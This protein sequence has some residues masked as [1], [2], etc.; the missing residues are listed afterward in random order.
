MAKIAGTPA[1]ARRYSSSIRPAVTRTCWKP[2]IRTLVA[3]AIPEASSAK[4]GVSR[5][6]WWSPSGL[7]PAAA[8]GGSASLSGAGRRPRQR[9]ARPTRPG[10]GGMAGAAMLAC[11]LGAAESGYGAADAPPRCMTV[12]RAG[13]PTWTAWSRVDSCPD[14]SLCGRSMVVFNFLPAKTLHPSACTG[15]Y[16]SFGRQAGAGCRAGV[17]ACVASPLGHT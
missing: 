3:H 17:R 5:L 6:C 13:P 15:D 9:G 12:F 10:L 2:Q 1:R 8:M 7:P 11:A 16:A 4:T 14:L